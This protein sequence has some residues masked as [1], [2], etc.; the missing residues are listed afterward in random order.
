MV[1]PAV[2]TVQVNFTN[3]VK[4]KKK[5]TEVTSLYVNLFFFSEEKQA[6]D[7]MF[8]NLK[9]VPILFSTLFSSI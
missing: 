2:K 3:N 9:N 5:N 8:C 7:N 1:C 4:K 6:E